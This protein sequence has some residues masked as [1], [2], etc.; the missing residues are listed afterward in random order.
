MQHTVM[1]QLIVYSPAAFFWA[2]FQATLVLKNLQNSFRVVR[3]VRWQYRKILWLK[4][5]TDVDLYSD[6][7]KKI[8]EKNKKF[9]QD[10]LLKPCLV[11]TGVE[12]R[13]SSHSKK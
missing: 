7:L 5:S 6:F 4:L 10:K 11:S 1:L 8:V 9:Q 3:I 13:T 12:V 2:K